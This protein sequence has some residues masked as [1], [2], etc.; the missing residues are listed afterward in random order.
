MK[1][2]LNK[3]K[4]SKNNT[5]YLATRFNARVHV[6]LYLSISL[7]VYLWAAQ[8]T[9][10]FKSCRITKGGLFLETKHGRSEKQANVNLS[11]WPLHTFC[12][13]ALKPSTWKR[14]NNWLTCFIRATVHSSMT[15]LLILIQRMS[16]G[17]VQILGMIPILLDYLNADMS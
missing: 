10:F 6:S 12:I 17:M 11:E 2:H 9:L 15:K 1:S 14:I 5:F 16:Q 13:P 4:L 3:V 7:H 8:T